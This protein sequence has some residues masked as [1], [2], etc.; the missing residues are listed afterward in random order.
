M[1]LCYLCGESILGLESSFSDS[2]L[3]NSRCS[4]RVRGTVL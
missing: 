2:E 3:T 4:V 1:N